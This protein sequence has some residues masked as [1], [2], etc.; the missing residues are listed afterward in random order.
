MIPN[1][2][3]VGAPKCGTTAWVDYL[4]SH[5][6][7]FFSAVK[8]P[9]YFCSDF[10]PGWRITDRD[11]YLALF[12]GSEDATVV[13]EASVRYLYSEV[14]A[15]N[16]RAFNPDA[17]IIILVRDQ[18]AYL[19]SLH[20]Q[21]IFNGIENVPDFERA[22]RMS[23]SRDQTNMP[24]WNQ[25]SVMLDY[26]RQ[27]AFSE[28]VERFT[29]HFPLEQIRIFHFRDWT[30]DPRSTYLEILRFL[31]VQ[32][33]GRTEFAPVNEA[34]RHKLGL[35]GRFTQYPPPWALKA[36]R[37]VKR[38]TGRSKPPLVGLIRK[39]NTSR[40]YKIAGPSAEL[41]EEIRA[42]YAED[43][44]RLEPLIWRPSA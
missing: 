20:N 14:A 21:Q 19:P 16:I 24:H 26:R 33:D 6:E 43:N 7:I 36:S 10:S 40:G 5:P 32:D 1:L 27:G 8:E 12:K 29:A 25:E 2:F 3:I 18:V 15:A 44:A 13:G 28:Q 37:I 23:G 38:L 42:Y 35:L 9:Y 22:W 11:E 31:G 17:K 41:V 34:K 4:K 30:R 39:I